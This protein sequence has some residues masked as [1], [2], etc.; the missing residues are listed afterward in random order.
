MCSFSQRLQRPAFVRKTKHSG[1]GHEDSGYS[2]VVIR[3]G[4][5][6]AQ[7]AT[8]AGRLGYIGKVEAAKAALKEEPIK[9]LVIEQDHRHGAAT[10]RDRLLPSEAEAAESNPIELS[11]KDLDSVLRLEAYSWPRLVFS[12]L[13]KS[14]HIILDGCTAEGE[15]LSTP[16]DATSSF[17]T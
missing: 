8:K 4:V 12:P 9:E 6:P 11:E 16:S 2:Y 10:N 3:R 7:Q 14:G 15:H 1:V 13:K 5:R 17:H